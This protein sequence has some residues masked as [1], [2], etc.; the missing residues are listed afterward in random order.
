M[1]YSVEVLGETYDVDVRETAAGLEVSVADGPYEPARLTGSTPT[2]TLDLNGTR[3]RITVAPD[4]HEPGTFA[5]A[6]LG[7][8]PLRAVTLD[9][10]T[11]ATVL[12]RGASGGRGL[13]LQ[14]SAMPGVIVE[15][16]VGPGQSVAKGDV[17]LILEAMKMQNEICAAGDAVVEEVFV[18]PGEAVSAGAK[19]VKFVDAG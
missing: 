11:K 8:R 13:T 1:R 19:L 7:A 10:L 4:P 16:R 15:V 5:V 9:A 17:L 18:T 6:A 14:R 3:T 12:A 2:R